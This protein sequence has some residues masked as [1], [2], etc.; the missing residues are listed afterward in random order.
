MTNLDG[1]NFT[2]AL[3]PRAIFHGANL[4]GTNFTRAYLYWARFEGVDLSDATGL[5][6]AQLDM[7]C[8]DDKTVLPPGLT[9]PA[10]WPCGED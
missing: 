4:A 2:G 6:Q 5:T 3:L 9:E 7:T 1:V 8:G 10:R